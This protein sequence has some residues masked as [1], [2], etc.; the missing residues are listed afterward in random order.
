MTGNWSISGCAGV[1]SFA[2]NGQA[3]AD[4]TCE[5]A[6][7]SDNAPWWFGDNGSGTNATIDNLVW[8]QTAPSMKPVTT[9]IQQMMMAAQQ[10]APLKRATLAEA[11]RVNAALPCVALYFDGQ[12][13]FAEVPHTNELSLLNTDYTIESWVKIM[14]SGGAMLSKRGSGTQEGYVFE[15]YATESRFGNG[16]CGGG[17]AMYLTPSEYVPQFDADI[18][19]GWHHIA[20]TYILASNTTRIWLD[21]QLYLEAVD[22]DQLANPH[23]LFIWV[24]NNGQFADLSLAGVRLTDEVLYGDVF[25]PTTHKDRQ[26]SCVVAIQ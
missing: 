25:D 8:R 4:L 10:H 15:A 23:R 12:D 3:I 19:N 6:E 5:N 17:A 9:A 7:L 2:L 21:G 26:H 22:F 13:D 18:A 16:C 1:F 11:S 14:R 20:V 24:E